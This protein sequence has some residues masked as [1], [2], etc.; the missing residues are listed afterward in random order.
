MDPEQ[1]GTLKHEYYHD[2][3]GTEISSSN[4]PGHIP[5]TDK[6]EVK[7][8]GSYPKTAKVGSESDDVI[9]T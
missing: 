5:L 3:A 7:T 1:P 6:V 9:P 8:H 4:N 2:F